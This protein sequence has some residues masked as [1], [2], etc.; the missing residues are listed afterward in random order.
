MMQS[1]TTQKEIRCAIYI[2]VSTEEQNLHGLSLP[3]QRKA[4]TD[5]A[6]LNGYQIAGFYADEGISARKPM[7]YRKDLLRLLE[8]VKKNEID[9]ILITKL[10]RWFRNIQDYHVTEEILRKHNCYW[11]TVFEHYDSSTANGQMVINI[12]L[13]VN[14][15]E[16]DRTSE[17]IRS[18]MEYKRSIGEITSGRC[19]CYGYLAKDRHLVKDPASAPL[20]E[21]AYDYYFKVL[22]IQKTAQYIQIKYGKRAPSIY[23]IRQLFRNETYA[24]IDRDNE[25]YCAPYLT[26]EQWLFIRRKTPLRTCAG[27]KA[28]YL[29][30]SLILCPVCGKNYTGY[31]KKRRKKD[32]SDTIKLRYRCPNKNL[33]HSCPHVSEEELEHTLLELLSPW[34]TTQIRLSGFTGSLLDVYLSLAK[35]NKIIFWHTILE[36]IELDFHDSPGF[37]PLFIFRALPEV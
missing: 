36:Q 35:Q 6:I 4:L 28:A 14:Q 12:M 32:G 5:Y 13:S 26:K 30:G 27:Q 33:R 29:F 22:S 10:D 20:I 7:K 9:M 16:C 15:A 17:R 25:N 21:D 37:K 11:K 8:D 34:L 19:A 18:V 24:G 2:R 3:A 23:Q 1:Q 31:Q